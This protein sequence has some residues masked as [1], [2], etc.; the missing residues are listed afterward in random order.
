MKATLF[1][2]IL[3]AFSSTS[4]AWIE[5][6][7][8]QKSYD[9][10]YQL[11]ND[12]FKYTRSAASYEEAFEHAADACFKHFKNGKRLSENEGLDIIDVCANPRS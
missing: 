9:F 5:K 2:I 8:V 11:K 4:F 7:P 6:A 12:T 3:V 1:M 10:K